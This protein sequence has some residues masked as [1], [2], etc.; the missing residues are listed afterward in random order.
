MRNRQF[1]RKVS[2]LSNR[3]IFV[4]LINVM[5][6]VLRLL[7]L[8]ILASCFFVSCEKTNKPKSN[9][10]SSGVSKGRVSDKLEEASGLVASV[11]NPGHLWVINDSGNEPE[12][13]LID[14]KADVVLTCKLEKIK[15]RDWE[16]IAIGKAP[17]S[18]E[19]YVYVAEV[20]DNAARYEFKY[21]YRFEEPVLAEGEK[22]SIEDVQTLVISLPDGARDME[23]TAI[24]H[25]TGD[26][27]LVSKR[28]ENVSVYSVPF[29]LLN[30]GDT[31]VP[32]KIT[33][34]PYN[35]VVAA[36]I[37]FDGKEILVKTYDEIFYWTTGDSLNV[38]QTIQLPETNLN[39]SPEP[40]GES[41]A[42]ALDGKGF[43]TLSES[44]DGEAAKLY[45]Y[46]RN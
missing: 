25:L 29:A 23:A 26:L 40:Q 15:N 37:S 12:V 46:K 1:D 18:D 17:G 31:L 36:D 19:P 38:V 6:N 20:G 7:R 45:F 22:I 9:L 43:Y 2:R 14:G 35:G 8:L 27:Y 4:P 28:E 33:T 24:D 21:L 32:K 16:D 42:W 44:K 41:I 39:Y 11:A 34:L 5:L 10:F 30:A 13:Y 3:T